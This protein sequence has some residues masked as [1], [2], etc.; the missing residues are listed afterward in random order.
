MAEAPTDVDVR[1]VRAALETN[2]TE[3][4]FWSRTEVEPSEMEWLPTGEDVGA[5]LTDRQQSVLRA[6]YYSGYY[7]WP[8]ETDAESLAESFGV[9]TPTVL[10]HLRRGHRQVMRNVFD[11]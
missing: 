8:R 11:S 1:R 3:V 5:C 10:Q 9:A 7:D 6:A 4:D 2:Y